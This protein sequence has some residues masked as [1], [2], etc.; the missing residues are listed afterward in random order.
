MQLKV[1]KTGHLRRGW[2]IIECKVDIA[3]GIYVVRGRQYYDYRIIILEVLMHVFFLSCK[4]LCAHPS[5]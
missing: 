4:A 5:P 2:V 3:I 1:I